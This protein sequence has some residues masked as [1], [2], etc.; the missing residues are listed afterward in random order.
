MNY[1][2]DAD[3]YSDVLHGL[4]DNL[5]ISGLTIQIWPASKVTLN[6][7]DCY[8][9]TADNILVMHVFVCNIY[10]K[11][12]QLGVVKRDYQAK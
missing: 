11:Q 12:K 5:I 8:S 3:F 7:N 10:A 2:H 6:W 4:T 9:Y 1:T